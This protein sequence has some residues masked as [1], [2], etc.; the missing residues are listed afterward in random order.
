MFHY[1]FIHSV[2]DFYS[3]TFFF[4]KLIFVII[5]TSRGNV[6]KSTGE[7]IIYHLCEFTR[8]QISEINKLN[9]YKKEADDV[10]IHQIK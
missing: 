7:K 2:L 1:H 5:K 10:I 3:N 6:H 8:N 4:L 9:I